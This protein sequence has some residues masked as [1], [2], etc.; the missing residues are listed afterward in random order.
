MLSVGTPFREDQLT[1]RQE[2]RERF[3]LLPHTGRYDIRPEADCDVVRTSSVRPGLYYVS[4]E[5]ARIS[6]VVN[7][8]ALTRTQIRTDRPSV[9]CRSSK[10]AK[11]YHYSRYLSFVFVENVASLIS[12]HED[13]TAPNVD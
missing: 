1:G 13:F 12:G 6:D 10:V 11:C 4:E 9:P 7:G 5:A 2:C 8:V 3:R